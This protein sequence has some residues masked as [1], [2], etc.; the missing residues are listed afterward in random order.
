VTAGQIQQ[1]PD[2][3][4]SGCFAFGD[5]TAKMIADFDNLRL[6]IAAATIFGN[7]FG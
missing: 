3:Q 1:Q 2:S 7:E 4:E 5:L 6:G